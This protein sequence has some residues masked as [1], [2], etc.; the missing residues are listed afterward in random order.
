M[1]IIKS[2]MN[3][4]IN[5]VIDMNTKYKTTKTDINDI[6]EEIE[7]DT[8]RYN[9]YKEQYLMSVGCECKYCDKLY[10]IENNSEE[11][12]CCIICFNDNMEIVVD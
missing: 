1:D 9:Y 8:D 7:E 10:G 12:D 2:K 5:E 11:I 3:E 4:M 6:L